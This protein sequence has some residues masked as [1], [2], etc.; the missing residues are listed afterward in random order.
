MHGESVQEFVH[1]EHGRKT[2]RHT[3]QLGVPPNGGAGAPK[4][5]TLQPIRH[6]GLGRYLLPQRFWAAP[7]GGELQTPQGGTDLHQVDLQSGVKARD[8]RRTAEEVGH[9]CA[10][11]W[12]QLYDTHAGR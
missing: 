5:G 9:E 2:L 8:V 1:D 4:R 10:A 11:S 3:F 12:A 7:Q 6:A